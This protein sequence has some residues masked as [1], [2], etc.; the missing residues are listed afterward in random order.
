MLT[1]ATTVMRTLTTE[2]SSVQ[3]MKCKIVM[4]AI[5][6]LNSKEYFSQLIRECSHAAEKPSE[7]KQKVSL[8][9][10]QFKHLYHVT[11]EATEPASLQHS[12]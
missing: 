3:L 4:K 9:A 12:V 8:K 11:S 2:Q 5:S 1:Q 10:S 6:T 7:S